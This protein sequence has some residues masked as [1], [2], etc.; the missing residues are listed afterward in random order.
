MPNISSA[1]NSI[2]RR[3]VDPSNGCQCNVRLWLR[4]LKKSVFGRLPVSAVSMCGHFVSASA[5]Y[6]SGFLFEG[7]VVTVLGSVYA[8][9]VRGGGNETMLARRLR[10]WIVAVRRNS[11]FAP[12]NPRSRNLTIAWRCFAS[13]NNRSICLRWMLELT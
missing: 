12:L 4:L 8:I 11:S 5:R 2:D 1:V 6:R 3:S 13:P 10:F 9:A 7:F